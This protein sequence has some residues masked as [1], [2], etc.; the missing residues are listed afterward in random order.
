MTRSSYSTWARSRSN[1][2]SGTRRSGSSSAAWPARR[3]AIRLCGSSSLISPARIRCAVNRRRRSRR[4][5]GGSRL[6]PTML[7]SGS[8]RGSSIGT[9]ASQPKPKNRGGGSWIYAGPTSFAAL[10]RESTVI[11]P[12]ATWRPWPPSAATSPRPSRLRATSRPSVPAIG[13]RW[14]C[15]D[16]DRRRC[17]SAAVPEPRRNGR[18]TLAAR[19]TG[20]P[21]RQA[22]SPSRGSGQDQHSTVCCQPRGQPRGADARAENGNVPAAA[23]AP[24]PHPQRPRIDEA[25]TARRSGCQRSRRPRSR[26][27]FEHPRYHQQ[28]PAGGDACARPTFHHAGARIQPS[29]VPMPSRLP[30]LT[31]PTSLARFSESRTGS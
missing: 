8:A 20:L 18:R 1:V 27:G 12:G 6:I 29:R 4:V 23:A 28:E 21:S 30:G 15:S 16:G 9:V 3:R 2:M 26:S 10:T 31:L 19:A 13:R 24:G 11:R 17:R 5:P 7:N 14:R 25:S 22:E